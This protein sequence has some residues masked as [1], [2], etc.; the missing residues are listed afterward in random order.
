VSSFASALIGEPRATAAQE[1]GPRRHRSPDSYKLRIGGNLRT[2][3]NLG[4][5]GCE[6]Q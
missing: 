2:E 5:S 4:D 1:N 3:P 6:I